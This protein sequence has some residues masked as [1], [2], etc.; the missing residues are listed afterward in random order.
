MCCRDHAR[1]HFDCPVQRLRGGS[2]AP[3]VLRAASP[4][5]SARLP[6]ISSR[7]ASRCRPLR[8]AQPCPER[9]SEGPTNVPKEFGLQQ[10]FSQG[11]AIHGHERPARTRAPVVDHPNDE[12]F[13]GTGLAIHQHG[14]VD[15]GQPSVSSST[16]CIA[17]LRAMKCFDAVWRAMRSR[18][19]FSSRLR[20]S[21]TCS[22]PESS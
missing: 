5:R 19:A 11:A 14:R 21:S 3:A 20:L 12:F 4:G 15:R 22:R 8:T 2:R 7:T 6:P 13:A 17:E 18:S 10:C 1:V 9:T 16:S